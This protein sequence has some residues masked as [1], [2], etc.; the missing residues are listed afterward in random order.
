M[1][2]TIN[3]HHDEIARGAVLRHAHSLFEQN[4]LRYDPQHSAGLCEIVIGEIKGPVVQGTSDPRVDGLEQFERCNGNVVLS[5]T[6][7][8]PGLI[9]I[10]VG[11]RY[12]PGS[13]H[14]GLLNPINMQPN[15]EVRAGTVLTNLVG[16]SLAGFVNDC[17]PRERPL[18]QIE[19]LGTL[20]G[21]EGKAVSL[22]DFVAQ[23]TASGGK[24]R[25]GILVCGAAS[26]AGKT[27]TSCA[28]MSALRSQD[29]D[30]T[31][32][33]GTGTA[34]FI[35]DPMRVQMGDASLGW[36]WT[37]EFT[38]TEQELRVSD[39][40][41]ACGVPSDSS[42]DLA[43]FAAGMCRHLDNQPGEISIVELADSLHYRTNLGL[44]NLPE[45]RSYFGSIVYVA[46][47]SLDAAHNFV[48]YIRDV[49]GWRDVNI[50]FGGPLAT[51]PE[52]TALRAEIDERLGITFLDP[53]D[54]DGLLNWVSDR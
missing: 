36:D 44:V 21:P 42:T 20:V 39:F 45:F 46:D 8:Q 49:L 18:T 24:K 27:T 32:I 23:G 22:Q 43:T 25:P 54:Q 16:G 35:S 51:A 9:A 41:D 38:L 48:H 52:H 2:K 11:N 5:L 13:I 14:G 47:S 26:D 31:Y 28:L 19:V 3:L 17:W 37:H 53:A 29:K 7:F 10:P 4:E 40:V 30:V 15:G 12:A 1:I 6:G 50:A 34:C 33:K